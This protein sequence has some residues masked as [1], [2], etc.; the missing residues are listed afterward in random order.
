MR[1]CVINVAVAVR[2]LLILSTRGLTEFAKD[3]P[4]LPPVEPEEKDVRVG[5]D[6]VL[7]RLRRAE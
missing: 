7:N 6:G 3:P 2:P 1:I 4:H 5:V